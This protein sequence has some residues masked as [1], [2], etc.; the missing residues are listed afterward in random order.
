MNIRLTLLQ[1]SYVA[2]LVNQFMTRPNN[3]YY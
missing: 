3:L 2:K 1:K